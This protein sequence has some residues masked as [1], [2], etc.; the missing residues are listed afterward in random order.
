[1][2]NDS[3]FLAIR[4]FRT[5]AALFQIIRLCFWNELVVI[6]MRLSAPKIAN[7]VGEWMCQYNIKD[8]TN[9]SHILLDPANSMANR[10]ACAVSASDAWAEDVCHSM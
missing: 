10:I 1:M 9:S 4:I 6:P 2:D 7:Y 8:S 3:Y 5:F